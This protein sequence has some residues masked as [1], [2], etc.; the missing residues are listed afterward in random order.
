MINSQP[1]RPS[2]ESEGRGS[3]AEE[4][5]MS[6]VIAS[7][8][9]IIEQTLRATLESLP[10]AQVVGSATGC[11]S[12]LH[13]V[14]DRKAE[15]VVIDSNLPI[16]DLQAFLRQIKGE[17]LQTHALVLTVTRGQARRALAAGADATFRRDGSA[18]QLGSIVT[19]LSGTSRVEGRESTSRGHTAEPRMKE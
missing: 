5:L 17:G 18:R 16:E 4:T 11:L 8:P 19:R 13:Q 10:S 14:R 15:L 3:V 1:S 6:T 9:G 7:T 12:A 2:P